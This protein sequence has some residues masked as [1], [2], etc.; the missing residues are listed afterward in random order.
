MH[1]IDGTVSHL[2]QRRCAVENT[3]ILPFAGP[4]VAGKFHV[5]C[6]GHV[7]E[8]GTLSRSN[9]PAPQSGPPGLSL[10]DCLDR[11][12][13]RDPSAMA[14]LYDRTVPW[15]YGLAIRILE[16][17]T[18]AEEIVQE[19]YF[20]A[21]EQAATCD[22]EE[23]EVL[24]WLLAMCREE[25]MAALRRD[26]GPA[27]ADSCPALMEAIGSGS[28]LYPP[29]ASLSPR[30]RELLELALFR[31]MDHDDLSL[32]AGI[33]V[34]EVVS[35]L[36]IASDR[37]R[38]VASDDPAPGTLASILFTHELDS[39]PS[40]PS[41]FQAEARAME[42]LSQELSQ[43]CGRI[44]GKLVESALELCHAHSA[45]ISILE[46]ADTDLVFRWH[47]ITGEFAP[48]LGGSLPRDESPCG[49]VLDRNAAQLMVHPERYFANLRDVTPKI[50]EVLLVPFRMLGEPVGTV[51]VLSHH[52]GTRFC[53]EDCRLITALSH[54]A[55]AAYVLRSSQE[56][57][58]EAR[59]EL[60][61]SNER[62]RRANAQL[63]AGLAR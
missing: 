39:R 47:A 14:E 53:A 43:P 6:E 29:L 32:H 56:A 41:D 44:L 37:L 40:R 4:G 3:L 54:F 33:P 46:R 24:G 17:R 13:T 62:L 49:I 31:A 30:Q 59:D 50:V 36:A 34:A 58:L 16:D 60:L 55:A 20:Q 61:R 35:E 57:A 18:E 11:M 48:H 9:C 8:G 42:A 21:W 12:A 1:H 26:G 52:E 28:L 19:V 15:V 25:A 23:Q 63:E 45:G 27:R 2:R 7:S 5:P 10:K 51:W 22:C 38:E